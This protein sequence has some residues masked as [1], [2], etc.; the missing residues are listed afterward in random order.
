M[1]DNIWKT[2]YR[3][4]RYGAINASFLYPWSDCINSDYINSDK[5][6][7]SSSYPAYSIEY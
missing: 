3:R 7:V 1:H 2:K 4:H 6:R 5:D